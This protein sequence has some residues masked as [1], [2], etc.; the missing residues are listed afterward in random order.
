M[1]QLLAMGYTMDNI[2]V[3]GFS[4]EDV[5]FWPDM[6]EWMYDRM[7]RGTTLRADESSQ[8]VILTVPGMGRGVIVVGAHYDTLPY[9]G[10]SDNASG[11]ALLL[12]SAMRLLGQENYHTIVYVF[13]GAEEIGLLGARYFVENLSR[14][15]H[16]EIIMM[17]NADVL[18]EGEFFFYGA[19]FDDSGQPG[20]NA[21]SRQ[22]GAIADRVRETHDLQLSSSPGAIF[23]PS[24]QLVFLGHG[25][26]VVQLWGA[27]LVP[28]EDFHGGMILGEYG[29]YLK[30]TRV[31][32]SPRDDFRYI[33]ENW[34][35]K[36]AAAMR[37]FS[38]FLEELILARY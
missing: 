37:T 27:H 26:T 30:T 18:F 7:W 2:E 33:E 1:E 36:M 38:I 12:E 23:L 17:I 10:A 13:F 29:D 9:P 6:F 5:G 21:A 25:H 14:A 20:A 4:A 11:T 8:N 22:V 24:D 32:H 35:G 34:P 3:Q 28:A 15:R 31:L 16:D 19:G